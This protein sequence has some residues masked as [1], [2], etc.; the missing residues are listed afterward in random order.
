MALP[1]L[2]K[3]SNLTGDRSERRLLLLTMNGYKALSV[4]SVLHV[5]GRWQR[6]PVRALRGMHRGGGDGN[7]VGGIL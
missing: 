7:R 4:Y 1:A 6:S 5:F 2:R 3:E